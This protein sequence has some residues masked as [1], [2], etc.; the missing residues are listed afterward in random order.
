MKKII[1]TLLTLMLVYAGSA[2]K[3]VLSSEK[4]AGIQEPVEALA[5]ETDNRIYTKTDVEASYPG[6]DTAWN[7]FIKRNLNIAR[8]KDSLKL[9]GGKTFSQTVLVQFVVGKDGSLSA[10]KSVSKDAEVNC[11]A[12]AVRVMKRSKNWIPAQLNGKIVNSFK[13]QAITFSF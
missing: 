3:T 12:E 8:V 6:G 11:A 1:I 5:I 7:S 10:F 4:P 2:Q 9:P 13:T